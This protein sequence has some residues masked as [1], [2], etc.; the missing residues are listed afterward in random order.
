MAERGESRDPFSRG[1]MSLGVISLGVSSLEEPS[2]G[3]LLGESRGECLGDMRGDMRGELARSGCLRIEDTEPPCLIVS[4][5][6]W[7]PE[8]LLG[9]PGDETVTCRVRGGAGSG[10]RRGDCGRYWPAL[11]DE[12]TCNELALNQNSLI[13]NFVFSWH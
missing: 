1:V 5:G 10:P 12:R 11:T 6:L 9:E 3:V 8:L 4:A 2:R 13:H 7:L